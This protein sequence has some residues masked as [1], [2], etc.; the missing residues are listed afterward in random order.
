M[1]HGNVRAVEQ[2][3]LGWGEDGERQ[4]QRLGVGVGK[5]NA[6]QGQRRPQLGQTCK[7]TDRTMPK[8]GRISDVPTEL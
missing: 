6:S 3:M 4:Q 2:T 8:Q 7:T 5:G 1:L